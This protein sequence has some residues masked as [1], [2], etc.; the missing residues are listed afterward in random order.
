MKADNISEKL[1]HVFEKCMQR[2]LE[3]AQKPRVFTGFPSLDK[4]TTGFVKESLVV[5]AGRPAMGKT[6]IALDIARNIAKEKT[7]VFFS[8]ELL[9]QTLALQLLQKNGLVDYQSWSKGNISHNDVLAISKV[10]YNSHFRI[11]DNHDFTIREMQKLCESAD[12]LGAVIIDS[13]RLIDRHAYHTD[14]KHCNGFVYSL[15]SRDLKLMAQELN[16]PVICTVSLGR[17]IEHRKDKR[18]VLKEDLREFGS[19]E[20]DADQILLLYRDRY[21]NP[22]T[23]LGEIAECIVSKNRY[24]DCGTVELL[25]NPARYSF[26]ETK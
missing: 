21:Y 11:F 17:Q 16:V 19:L 18:P 7:V 12:N 10:L 6:A 9:R 13:F 2:V 25:W 4:M 15:I 24:G 26:S 1:S 20:Q 23:P 3:D 8:L 5:I 22:D 14:N